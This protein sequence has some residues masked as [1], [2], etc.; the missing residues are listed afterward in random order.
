MRFF[1]RLATLS[2]VIAVLAG[3]AA[4]QW[5]ERS[6]N[7]PLQQRFIG[8]TV[9]VSKGSS[10]SGVANQLESMGLVDHARALVLYAR[11]YDLTE[12]KAG[13][14]AISVNDTPITLLAKMRKGT[15]K[16]YQITLPE[17]LSAKQLLAKIH[18]SDGIERTLEFDQLPA[19]IASLG[20]GQ[21]DNIEGL[22]FP[23]SYAFTRGQSDRQ[24]IAVAAARLQLVLAQQWQ[25][26]P[27]GLPYKTPYEALIM[28][29]IVERETGVARE[30]GEIAGVFVR[31]LNKR[32]RL[33][34]DPTVIYGMGDNYQ[35]RITRAD[36]RRD[37]SYNTYTRHGL[38]P[39]PIAAAGKEAIHAA[40]NPKQ[41]TSLYFV[42]KGDGTHQ[43][44]ATLEQH[45]K[46]VKEYQLRRRADYRSTP[47]NEK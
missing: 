14:Y 46:A 18:A 28:A 22:I 26:R 10:F 45:N 5:L 12:I 1:K 6:M 23:D 11:L 41:G 20:Y 33:Q 40:L 4:Q 39:T 36:L 47:A 16:Y 15:V 38:P 3:V 7:T 13:E 32:M 42:A 19:Y 27:K 21:H 24:I 35:G 34:T 37:T 44:S 25:Q 29:S 30:R 43:F 17:G 2:V 8:N 9:V 31:R